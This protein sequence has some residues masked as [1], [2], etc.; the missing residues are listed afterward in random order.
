MS[1]PRRL[2]QFVGWE[3]ATLATSILFGH[4]QSNMLAGVFMFF[5]LNCLYGIVSQKEL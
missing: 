1:M 3:S 4:W 2:A 5:F